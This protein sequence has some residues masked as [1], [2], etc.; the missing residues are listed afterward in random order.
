MTKVVRVGPMFLGKT[1]PVGE[2]KHLIS[3]KGLKG[4]AVVLISSKVIG[5]SSLTY[6]AGA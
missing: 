1:P 6:V 3:Q 2:D 4:W 5:V